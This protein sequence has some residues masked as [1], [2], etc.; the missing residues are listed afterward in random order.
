MS[1][2]LECNYHKSMMGILKEWH[3]MKEAELTLSD[4]MMMMMM[5]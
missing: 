3:K 1:Q 5:M 2:E 4:E